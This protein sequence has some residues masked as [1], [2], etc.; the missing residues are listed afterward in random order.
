M[1]KLTTKALQVYNDLY[2][3]GFIVGVAALI[4]MLAFPQ[5]DLTR[6]YNQLRENRQQRQREFLNT[7]GINVQPT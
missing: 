3:I 5:S 2:F 7:I 6:N 1:G 4:Y